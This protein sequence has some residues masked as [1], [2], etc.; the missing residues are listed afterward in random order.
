METSK[1]F[2]KICKVKETPEVDLF[3]SQMSNK[4]PRY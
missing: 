3:V 4:L 1:M 2:Q